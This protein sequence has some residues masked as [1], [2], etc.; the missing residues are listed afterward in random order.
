MK[1]IQD[2]ATLINFKNSAMERPLSQSNYSDVTLV[3]DDATP[4][5]AHKF[6]VATYSPVLRD[7]RPPYK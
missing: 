3:S 4:F 7:K 2:K 6:V 5:T 1:I